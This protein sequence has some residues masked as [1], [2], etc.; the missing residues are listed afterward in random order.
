MA[1]WTQATETPK[2]KLGHSRHGTAFDEGFRE[3]PWKMEGIGKVHFPITSSN[4]DVQEWFDQGIALMHSFWYEEAERSFR[5]CLKLDPECAMAYWGLAMAGARGLFSASSDAPPPKDRMA[6]FIE[7]AVKRMGHVSDRE[8][9]YIGALRAAVASDPPKNYIMEKSPRGKIFA[10]HLEKLVLKYPEDIEAK[11]FLGLALMDKLGG[12]PVDLILHEVLKVDPNHPGAHHYLIHNWD[13]RDEE[14]AIADSAVYGKIAPGIGHANHMPGHIYSGVGM[15]HEAAIWMDQATRVEKAYFQKRL[16]LPTET[17]NYS[18][19]RDYLCYIQEQLGMANAAIAGGRELLRGPDEPSGNEPNFS[20]W[21]VS[22]LAR[23]LVKFEKWDEILKLESNKWPKDMP[24]RPYT[25]ALAYIGLGRLDE[26][27][28]QLVEL[29]KKPE[30]NPG[31]DAG[32]VN[33][34]ALEVEGLLLIAKGDNLTGIGKL[35]A[36]AAAEQEDRDAHWYST[37]PPFL[38]HSLWNLVG[39][40]YLKSDSPKLAA[41]AFERALMNVE[42]DGFALSGLTRA[43]YALGDRTKATEY[44]GRLLHVWS[45]ADA[46]LHWMDDCKKLGLVA[47]AKDVS[48]KPQRVYLAQNLDSFGPSTWEPYPAPPLDAKNAGGKLV[49][50]ED[51]R[52]KNVVLVFFLGDECPHCMEQ[53]QEIKNNA[54]ALAEKNTVVLAISP[55]TPDQNKASGKSGKLGFTLL[56]DHDL[57]TAKRYHSYDDFED[58]QLHSTVLIDEGGRIYWKKNGGDPF[59]DV[60]FL[61]AEIDK[62]NAET[63]AKKTG[64]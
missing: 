19:N 8:Q 26:A 34:P 62:C 20:E 58:I 49:S 4:K 44:Y 18:H 54:D 24:L 32:A 42:N 14:R 55:Q 27:E 7:G 2:D 46:G 9:M 53:L 50:L 59:K 25:M 5:W 21:K 30:N 1:S 31:R 23:S 64:H 17:W 13:G 57:Q 61:L 52:G 15:W 48:P 29:K 63:A 10:D 12:Y 41:A 22:T 38:P 56:S 11:A 51:Y 33:Q 45:G 37:D 43:Y 47:K 36:A 28:K 6:E 39:E 16:K 35:Q 40:A 3:R 60:K